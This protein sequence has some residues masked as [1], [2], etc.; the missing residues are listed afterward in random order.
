MKKLSRIGFDLGVLMLTVFF[1]VN[2]VYAAAPPRLD[3]IGTIVESV[4][5][6]ILP[7]GGLISLVMI[8]YGG[9]MWMLSSGD[10]GKLKQA[11]GTL[12]WAILGLVFLTLM[13][14]ILKGIFDFLG[15]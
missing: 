14:T 1:S 13:G 2:K 4:A 10:P 11:Q 6:L 15:N 3:E 8:V 7:I 12:T 5:D 9:Y